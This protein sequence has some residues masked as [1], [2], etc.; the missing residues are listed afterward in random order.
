MSNPTPKAQP[1]TRPV[2]RFAETTLPTAHGA[3]RTVVFRDGDGEEHVALV[4]GDIEGQSDVLCRVH[5]ECMTSEVFGSLR[6]DC[7]QQLDQAMA[8]VAQQGLGV[9]LYLRQEGRGIGLGNKIRAYALQEQ[10]LDTV[11]ANRQLGLPDDARNYHV[12]ADMLRLLGVRSVRL[13]TNNPAKVDG[14]VAAGF[15]VTR[16]VGHMVAVDGL[17]Q[18]YVDT[19]VARM[20]HLRDVGRPGAA[21]GEMKIA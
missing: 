6:C 12:A 8:R 21:T 15:S 11:D 3:F 7:K 1:G 2:E 14:L 16:R 5:S 19:K 18:D 13:L 4:V 9:V 20:G 17:A 10:G